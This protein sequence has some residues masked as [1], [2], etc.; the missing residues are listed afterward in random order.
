MYVGIK[1]RQVLLL[2]G[3]CKTVISSFEHQCEQSSLIS[4]SRL[5][6]RV[7]VC[8]CLQNIY[9]LNDSVIKVLQFYAH[10]R[11]LLF[12]LSISDGEIIP[13]TLPSYHSLVASCFFYVFSS[14]TYSCHCSTEYLKVSETL[15]SHISSFHLSLCLCCHGQGSEKQ[16]GIWD[17]QHQK[18]STFIHSSYVCHL[19]TFSLLAPDT[20]TDSTSLKKQ[21]CVCC[22]AASG[23]T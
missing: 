4:V 23:V 3:C 21:I 1:R 13:L 18:N 7:P 14:H 22:L 12:E 10:R 15:K 8:I 16:F 5:C 17:K 11:A 20:H 6:V 2:S 9:S 19:S